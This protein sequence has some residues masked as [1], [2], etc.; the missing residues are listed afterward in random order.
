VDDAI[1]SERLAIP[2][3]AGGV[4]DQPYARTQ[5]MLAAKSI[6]DAF[7]LYSNTP[8]SDV[9]FSR[10]Y[11]EAWEVVTGLENPDDRIT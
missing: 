4:L 1:A 6:Y 10:K 7:R 8:L 11:P 9:D 2:L 3:V 5:R